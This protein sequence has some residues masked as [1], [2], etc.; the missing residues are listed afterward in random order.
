[1][2]DR[3]SARQPSPVKY[4]KPSQCPTSNCLEVGI[5]DGLVYLRDS[6]DRSIP[7]LVFTRDE[8]VA[9]VSSVKFGEFDFDGEPY[10]DSSA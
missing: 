5:A 6:K 8:W 10:E 3:V 2:H 9:F 4:V 1:M 7:P